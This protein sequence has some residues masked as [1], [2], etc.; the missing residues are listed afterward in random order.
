MYNNFVGL[1][2][3]DANRLVRLVKK[4][5]RLI[6]LFELDPDGLVPLVNQVGKLIRYRP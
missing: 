2:D 5:D 6:R 1:F 3:V 4:I